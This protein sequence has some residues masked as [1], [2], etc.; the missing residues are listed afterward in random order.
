[1]DMAVMV[2]TPQDEQL[3]GTPDADDIRAGAGNDLLIGNEGDD[4]LHGEAGNDLLDGG[5]GA[6]TYLFN[7]G[8]GQDRL[9]PD[10]G[11][12]PGQR[13]VLQWGAGI[14]LAD[15]DV[16][17]Q[18]DDLL[19]SLKG[20]SDMVT[21]VNYF[22]QPLDSRP[23]I[24]FAD[25]ATWDAP[26][27]D[28]KINPNMDQLFGTP[29]GE[30][31]DGGLGN[32]LLVGDEGNDTLYGDAGIDTLDGGPGDDTFV[33]G[34]GDGQDRVVS[35]WGSTPG[36]RDQLL[37]GAGIS[38]ADVD[39]SAQGSD[40]LLSLKGSTDSVRVVDYFALSPDSRLVIRFADGASWDAQAI[41]RKLN[42]T[43]DVLFGTPDGEVLDGGL[44]DDFIHG[45]EGDDLLYGD[46]GAD[47]LDGGAG[48]D[49]Y[50]FGR[51][52]GQDELMTDWNSEPGQRDQLVLGAG[53]GLADV[54][55][56]A[57]DSDLL[58]SLRGSSDAVRIG[59]YF[60]QAPDTRALIRFA[61]GASW[62]AAVIDRKVNFSH[63][64]LFGTPDGDVL[65]GGL[66][67]DLLIGDE[68]DDLLYGDAGN[69][70][71][72]GGPGSDTFVFGRGDGQDRLM[73]DWGAAPGQR[74]QLQLGADIGLADVDI[75][76]DGGDLILS[77]KGSSDSVRLVNYF[78]PAPENRPWIRFANGASWDAQAIDRKLS[79]QDDVLHGT[80]N[81]D[82]LDGGL[83]NDLLV[84]NEGDDLLYGDAGNDI[85][86]GGW[87]ADTY[88]FGRGDGQDRI[89]ADWGT[90]PGQRDQLQL[91]AGIGLADVDVSIDADDLILS[92]KGGTDSMRIGNYFGQPVD[93]RLVIR[94]ADGASWDAQAIDRKLNP[95]NDV[96]I[97]TAQGEVLDGGLGDDVLQGNE[98]D[99]LLY[100]DD[101]N[102]FLDGGSGSDTYVF[103][104][105]DGQDRVMANQWHNMPA[106]RDQLVL[107]A[108]IGL[109]DVDVSAANG[110]LV[111]S[112]KGSSDAVSLDGYFGQPLDNRVLIRFADGATWDGLA[113]DRKLNPNDDVLI[114]TPNG[115]VLDGGLGDDLLIGHEGDDL[116]YGDAGND[117]LDG[118]PGADTFVFG[119]GDGEDRLTPDWSWGPG[120]RDQLR[121]GAG[122]GLA[123][124]D[125]TLEEGDLLL[126]LKDSSDSVRLV[127]YMGPPPDNRPLIIFADGLSW[128]AAAIDR[129]LSPTDDLLQGTPGADVLDGGLGNDQLMGD[130]GADYLY[131]DAGDDWLQGGLG[132]DTLVGASGD[133]T[134]LVDNAQDVV[135]ERAQDGEADEVRSFVSYTAPD[136]IETLSLVGG[137]AIDGF[138]HDLGMSLYGNNANNRL[139]GGKGDDWLQG[140][141]GDDSVEGG[142]GLDYLSGGVGN[143]SLYGGEGS[144]YLVGDEGIDLMD[145]GQGDDTYLVDNSADTVVE[146]PN[147]G[148]DDQ[149]RSWV[150]YTAS[151][152]IESLFLIGAAD[153]NAFAHDEGMFL[154]GNK[155]NNRMVG[156]QGDDWL[157]DFGGTDTLEGGA[158]FDTLYG[159]SG[160]DTLHGNEGNDYLNGGEGIDAMFGGK[161]NDTYIVE[162]AGDQV[163]EVEGEGTDT[164][165]ISKLGSYTLGD[166][167]ENG[168]L[169]VLSS[170]GAALTGNGL[171]N[172]LTGSAFNDTLAGAGGN[173]TLIDA[174]ATSNDV[175]TWGRS[176]GA[177]TLSDS[178][179]VDRL[180]VL[181]GTAASQVW[182]RK[183]NNNLE[184]S[185]IGT[186]DSFTINNW[187]GSAAN[188]VESIR[189]AD[190]KALTASR[191]QNLVDAMASFAPP[192]QGQTT[193]PANYQSALN[194]A[195]AANWV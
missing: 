46:A 26:A 195:I 191:A 145:G 59:G 152:H 25:G 104:R 80:P 74:D 158:G 173:D 140:F 177:D 163:N 7:R 91:G 110:D 183:V 98:G 65:D 58:L 121:L 120:Q 174:S 187:Y 141:K 28:R 61:D 132:A 21:L 134:Y 100:G 81:A 148:G 44:G 103:G 32:D 136:Y 51:G 124:V 115:D 15:V 97:G 5:S 188:Q 39:V 49:T 130:D 116:L 142:D 160:N 17:A 6:D 146:Q 176:L 190:G 167:V 55:V 79:P 96:L 102:D 63:D 105:G 1:M 179:G 156:G 11:S 67:D 9:M 139:I 33:F 117:V 164:V 2:G 181:S 60:S 172:V 109:A 165:V 20:S 169:S 144:D 47:V 112:L 135:I 84:G 189:L 171:A 123:D 185:V 27:I 129:K 92:L 13:D 31:L 147:G 16:T 72:D 30:L 166:N 42:P 143:D 36:H 53:I 62:D 168:T 48:S 82:F 40:L 149:V 77:I 155:G 113:I 19:L 107:G 12:A 178:G 38:L 108:G 75:I 118:G 76:P 127:N 50:L 73:P 119:R 23:L 29:E 45:K 64:Q 56:T 180:D 34:R 170:S 128:D 83:G 43:D 3:I 192:A 93:S 57:L 133:D 150:S 194:G 157:Q 86:D 22:G 137:A 37:L 153:T 151:K 99:D 175:Y 87:G 184:V 154:Y 138:A 78:G 66:G 193:L 71:L 85:L 131:G 10:W 18:G 88:V 4:V 89:M 94:F 68:G 111:L 52:D 70:I 114:G 182:L 125:V 90:I 162:T 54:D 95:N 161:D 14:G 101:G 35:D 41:D 122:I 106:Q 8:D 69:D 126:R 159:G 24:R 186:A